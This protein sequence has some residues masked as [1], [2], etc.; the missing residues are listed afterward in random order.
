MPRPPQTHLVLK[1][2]YSEYK[3]GVQNYVGVI[4]KDNTGMFDIGQTY[5]LRDVIS[6]SEWHDHF[7]ARNAA[8]NVELPKALRRF[9]RPRD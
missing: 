9:N 5:I 7:L 4:V 2:W 6:C 8:F 3:S 1:D